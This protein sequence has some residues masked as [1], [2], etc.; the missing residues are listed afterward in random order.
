MDSVHTPATPIDGRFGSIRSILKDKNTPATGQSV[1]FFSRDAYKTISPDVSALSSSE[2]DEMPLID[3]FQEAAAEKVTLSRS[4]T[5]KPLAH[6][7]FAPPAGSTT[8]PMSPAAAES[9]RLQGNFTPLPPPE[10]SGIFD[11]S[12]GNIQPIPAEGVPLLD[13]AVEVWEGDSSRDS[14]FSQ[15]SSSKSFESAPSR[16][17][18]SNP[19]FSPPPP[20]TSSQLSGGIMWRL[21]YSHLAEAGDPRSACCACCQDGVARTESQG[22]SRKLGVASTEQER[23][24]ETAVECY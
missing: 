20:S 13:G 14:G 19:V 12:A 2:V 5:R 21:G 7:L 17:Q 22:R 1:R 11:M 9:I 24:H 8:P 3:K 16:M 18:S 23:K 4:Q 6:D 10:I 15:A